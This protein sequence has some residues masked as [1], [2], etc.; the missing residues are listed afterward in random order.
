MTRGC[1]FIFAARGDRG[2]LHVTNLVAPQHGHVLTVRRD[3]HETRE[4]VPGASTFYYQLRAF[5]A[6]VRGTGQ[7]LTTPEEAVANMCLIDQ[8]YFAA[9]LQ[10]R[11]SKQAVTARLR[12]D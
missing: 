6:A 8:V 4:S 9:G 2:E 5:V 11:N 10:P 12:N 3:R 1:R 7:L